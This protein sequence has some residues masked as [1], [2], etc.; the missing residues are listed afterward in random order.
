MK[1]HHAEVNGIRAILLGY[2]K[3]NNNL[4][5]LFLE[6]IKSTESTD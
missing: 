2:S 1:H 4:D 5:M 3:Q 6:I